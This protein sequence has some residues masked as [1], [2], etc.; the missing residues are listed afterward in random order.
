MKNAIAA[1]LLASY[2]FGLQAETVTYTSSCMLQDFGTVSG[3]QSCSNGLPGAPGSAGY[4]QARAN[5]SVGSVLAGFDLVLTG[6]G[7][8]VGGGPGRPPFGLVP[9]DW[10]ALSQG[11]LS[12]S[13]LPQ[14]RC[15]K[16]D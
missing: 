8:A 6:T 15:V 2:A 7:T 16:A 12:A 10:D 14:A 5:M 9:S 13:L 1:C 11:V 4:P 3:G